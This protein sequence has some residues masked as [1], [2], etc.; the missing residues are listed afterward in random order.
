M[1][2][3]LLLSD[4]IF[5]ENIAERLGKVRLDFWLS[6]SGLCDAQNMGSWL[7]TRLKDA[8]H[9]GSLKA[10]PR[11]IHAFFVNLLTGRLPSCPVIRNSLEAALAWPSPDPQVR[12]FGKTG[13]WG[14]AV[15]FVGFGEKAG[16]RTFVTVCCRGTLAGRPAV[17]SR[18]Y[19]QFDLLW[20][21]KLLDDFLGR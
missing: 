1:H 10:S 21:S 14:G 3:A 13:T 15:W 8:V 9:G 17:I 5:F 2:R 19:R 7:G 18:F 11:R 16:K 12:L 4:N 6:K 20:N